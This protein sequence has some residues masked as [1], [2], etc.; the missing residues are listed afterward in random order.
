MNNGRVSTIEQL[1][2]LYS[3]PAPASVAKELPC[4][5][6]HYRRFILASPYVSV[7]SIGPTGLDCSPRGDSPGFVHVLDDST[8]VIPDR[9]GNNRL[10]TLRNIIFAPH[11]ALLFMIPGL[12]ETIRINGQAYVTTD[13]D[14]LQRFV[15]GEKRPVT[16]IVVDIEQVYFQCARA[17]KRSKLWDSSK[18]VDPETLP[19]AG[20]LIK[21][22]V[23]EFEADAYDSVLKERQEKT[24]W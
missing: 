7:A 17:L 21:S 20:T 16:A 10:D 1:E 14:L 6:E 2:T 22:A 3:Q 11:V 8:L 19:S 4:L 9:R 13:P 18:H 5:N 12:N 24:L 15:V 23:P